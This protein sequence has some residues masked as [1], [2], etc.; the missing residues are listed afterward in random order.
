MK[1][2]LIIVSVF[3]VTVLIGCTDTSDCDTGYHLVDNQCA[4][5][6]TNDYT[7][8]I[9]YLE[10]VLSEIESNDNFTNTWFESEKEYY[11]QFFTSSNRYKILNTDVIEYNAQD[12]IFHEASIRIKYITDAINNL[13]EL[14]E[15]EENTLTS[16]GRNEVLYYIEDDTLYLEIEDTVENYF[17]YYRVKKN[18]E[19]KLWFDALEASKDSP[20]FGA[21]TIYTLYDEGNNYYERIMV[22]N[23]A[24]AYYF[25]YDYSFEDNVVKTFYTAAMDTYNSYDIGRAERH[26]DDDYYVVYGT[27]TY[28]EHK[29]VTLFHNNRP[30]INIDNVIRSSNETG[31]TVAWNLLDIDEWDY[32]END[33]VYLDCGDSLQITPFTYLE[34]PYYGPEFTVTQKFTTLFTNEELANPLGTLEYDIYTLEDYAIASALLDELASQFDVTTTTY[35]EFGVTKN[36]S[37][38][39]HDRFLPFMSQ[40][41]LDKILEYI[42]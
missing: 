32:I 20:F 24:N 22:D 5:I 26:F 7:T 29:Y 3:F 19:D 12:V 34:F 16:F 9:E 6:V 36:F 4:L 23:S 31:Y 42:E 35:T 14:A 8:Q 41:Y 21:T 33:R 40:E 10:T 1:K 38:G 2:Y 15:P 27:S 39:F 28:Y 13:I 30:S 11:V 17:G 37:D 25:E 18:D